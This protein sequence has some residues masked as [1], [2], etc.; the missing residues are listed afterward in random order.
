MKRKGADADTELTAT[1]ENSGFFNDIMAHC[2]DTITDGNT[3]LELDY[4]DNKYTCTLIPRQNVLPTPAIIVK[5]Y[6]DDKGIE[7]RQVNEYGTWLLEFKAGG[8]IGLINKAIPHVL[9]K[10][11]AQSCWSELCEIC[12]IPPRVMKTNTA[13]PQALNRAERMMKD[14]GAAAWFIIDDT[15]QIEWAESTSSK[16]EVYENLINLCNNEI[17]SY[18]F[19]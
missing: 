9:F 13:D 11:F 16:G 19:V 3:V 14:M 15:E 8:K 7:Y 6:T 12:G 18:N 17:S 10:R 5:D 2:W 1:L 4:I